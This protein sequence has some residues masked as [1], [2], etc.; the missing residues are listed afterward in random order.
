M[1]VQLV[2]DTKPLSAMKTYPNNVGHVFAARG[3]DRIF[4]MT[5]IP[6][7]DGVYEVRRMPKDEDFKYFLKKARVGKVYQSFKEY[8]EDESTTFQTLISEG[9]SRLLDEHKVEIELKKVTNTIFHA[10]DF[11][12]TVLYN[13]EPKNMNPTIKRVLEAIHG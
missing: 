4:I 13:L 12:E 5:L 9:A 2:T 6:I 7:T 10:L 1:N 11:T 3:E 8:L